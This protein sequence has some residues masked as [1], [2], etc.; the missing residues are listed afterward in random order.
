MKPIRKRIRKPD[1]AW[2]RVA[3]S[4]HL[5]GRL[6]FPYLP[7]LLITLA[8]FV[9]L[10][11]MSM[12]SANANANATGVLLECPMTDVLEG[13]SLEV[14]LV[15][16]D[17][18]TDVE[19]LGASW[20][21]IAG[22][23]AASDFSSFESNFE[24]STDP[25]TGEYRMAGS[26]ATSQDDLAEGDE[27]FTVGYALGNDANAELI[28]TCVVTINDDDPHVTSLRIA[29]SPAVGDT[30]GLNE[31]IEIEA[32]FNTPVTV[33]GRA[34]L[35]MWIGSRWYGAWYQSGS[36]TDTL[37][38]SRK[39]L[40]ED[41]DDNGIT[42]SPGRAQRDSNE[43]GFGGSGSILAAG[44]NVV[45][46]GVYS[47][48]K[49][50]SDHKVDWKHV[51]KITDVSV[52]SAPED[53]ESYHA[54]EAIEVQ[55][56]YEET[57]VVEGDKGVSIH[58]GDSDNNWRGARYNRGSGADT[59]V[60]SYTVKRT[61]FDEDGFSVSAGGKGSG[62]FGNG[63]I[64]SQATGQHS[65]RG[66]RAIHD[67]DGHLVVGS[68]DLVAP[69]ISSLSVTSE[70]SGRDYVDGDEIT[71]EVEFDENVIVSGSA[72]LELDFDGSP[73]VATLR[74][75]AEQRGSAED[76]SLG[77][78]S[79]TFVYTVVEGDH[80]PDGFAIGQ[81]K[82]SLSD[83]TIED[84]AG[85]AAI[86]DHD[87]VAAV[88]V[89]CVDARNM[90]PTFNE[91]DS[92]ARTVDENPSEGALV[93]DPVVATDPE[94][95]ELTYSLS[96]EDASTFAIDSASG[97]LRTTGHLSFEYRNTYS[98]RLTA[99]DGESDAHLDLT[100]HVT[101]IDEPG[102]VNIWKP[103]P[104]CTPVLHALLSDPDGGKT[105]VTWLWEIS[106]NGEENWS[107]IGEIASYDSSYSPLAA[108][109]NKFLRITVTYADKFGSGKSVQLV[110]SIGPVVPLQVGCLADASATVIR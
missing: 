87:A 20:R 53:G 9:A 102:R 62:Y 90:P 100:I 46:H 13:E 30:Y 21:V 22:T 78:Q 66:Y 74:A 31:E 64:R 65:S 17:D 40:W 49:N 69:K 45:A 28:E 76:E 105:D 67:L 25:E 1:A 39:V 79:L 110:E 7:L 34:H 27:T 92:A 84:A 24:W 86:L 18:A 85:N 36:G 55:L 88:A 43:R 6:R 3:P 73:R 2:R 52:I 32:V 106:D 101:D 104:L 109:A 94:G 10:Q 97:Q 37:T 103:T 82:L 51:V 42:L 108:D 23:A 91:G 16:A 96:G 77:S 89:Q 107:T 95:Q 70:P 12:A 93:G 59:L 33:Q 48:I 80:D 5:S 63:S 4:Q 47:G 72:Q 15:R 44:T 75:S 68:T 41:F 57:M 56:T 81:N 11:S 99:N 8:G 54:G 26:I 14:F 29:S 58:V 35:G 83:G 19:S 60:F 98:V 71:V 50:A 61:D 38:F